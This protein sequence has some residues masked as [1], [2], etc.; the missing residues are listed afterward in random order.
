MV[1]NTYTQG[2]LDHVEASW[3]NTD[4][5]ARQA[6]LAG[7]TAALVGG[8]GT[9]GH[10]QYGA[11]DLTFITRMAP[12]VQSMQNAAVP[13]T[14]QQ[15]IYNTFFQTLDGY[16][17]ANAPAGQ[18]NLD[19]YLSARNTPTPYTQMVGPRTAD[20]Y[21]L[22]KSGGTRTAGTL[23]TPGNVY[24]PVTALGTATVGAA[25]VITWTPGAAIPLVNGSAPPSQGYA[26]AIGALI[27]ITA[28]INGTLSLT[29]TVTGRSS[30]GA[31][32]TG[33]LWTATL[34]GLGVGATAALVIPAGITGQRITQITACAKTGSPTA[35]AGVF[36]VSSTMDRTPTS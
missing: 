4:A 3:R 20:L 21:W 16:L 29:A 33:Q 6:V 9:S 24:P 23:L 32:V 17:S 31:T 14:L 2:Y 34:D 27:T 10:T 13:D 26:P 25:G 30:A 36:T 7:M 19:L 1:S 11:G 22:Y 28:A 5:P 18:G 15:G 12:A 8:D 35:T